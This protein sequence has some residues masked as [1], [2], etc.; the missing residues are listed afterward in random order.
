MM[1]LDKDS[2]TSF[3]LGNTSKLLSAECN[4]LLEIYQMRQFQGYIGTRLFKT[5]KVRTRILNLT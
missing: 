5:L 4:A 3:G 2:Q 1:V